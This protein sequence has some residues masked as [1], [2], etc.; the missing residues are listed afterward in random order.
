MQ[1]HGDV[2]QNTFAK[3]QLNYIYEKLNCGIFYNRLRTTVRCLNSEFQT[4]EVI[5]QGSWDPEVPRGPSVQ[6]PCGPQGF[7]GSWGTGDPQIPGI[8][9]VLGVPMSQDCVPLSNHAILI[10]I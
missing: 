5:S 8:Q 9:G 2:L 4:V 3:K 7:T 1:P 10:V 6:S